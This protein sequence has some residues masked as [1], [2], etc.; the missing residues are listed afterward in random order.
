MKP[1]QASRP[2]GLLIADFPQSHSGV[3]GRLVSAPKCPRGRLLIRCGERRIGMHTYII[4]RFPTCEIGR[5]RGANLPLT[6][7]YLL[8]IVWLSVAAIQNAASQTSDADK[9]AAALAQAQFALQTA[10]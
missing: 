1:L 5:K 10:E 8:I 6:L 3:F 2:R 7:R 9:Q 4:S